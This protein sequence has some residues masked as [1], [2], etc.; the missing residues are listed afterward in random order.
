MLSASEVQANRYL[1]D[2]VYCDESGVAGVF[3]GTD[4]PLDGVTLDIVCT[5]ADAEVCLEFTT[6]TGTLHESV[7][8]GKFN[9]ECA[10]VKTFDPTVDLSG[11]YLV[12]VAGVEGF[13]GCL[14]PVA[15]P[16][17]YL[18]TV[19]VDP[20]TLPEDC[21]G[22][23]TPVVGGPP[24]NGNGDG[25]FCDP[26]DGPFPEGQILGDGSIDQAT[27]EAS[28]SPGPGD[29]VHTVLVNDPIEA[30]CSLFA[31]FGYEPGEPFC[32]DGSVNA[33]GETCDPP[34]SPAGGNGNLCR[35][36]CT[37]CGDSIVDPGEDCDDGNG[38]PGDGCE[39]D[40]T[41]SP[42][43]GN[44]VLD[45]GETCDPPGFPAGGNGKLCR[46]S[47]TVC[48]DGI[49]NNGEAC[50]DGN[51]ING[52][53]C[54]NDCTGGFL[55]KELLEG[56]EQIGIYL[57]T[58]TVF[59]F[60]ITYFGPAALVLDTVPAEFEI[61]EVV[62]SDGTAIFFQSG[63]SGKSATK[64]EWEVPAGLNTLTVT[65]QTRPSPGKGHKEPVFKPTSCGPLPL[66][67][68]ATATTVGT[69]NALVVEA[70]EGAKPCVEEKVDK[71]ILRVDSAGTGN[72]GQVRIRGMLDD[73]KTGGDLA[74]SLLNGL[75]TLIVTDGAE[76]NAAIELTNCAFRRKGMIRCGSPRAIIKPSRKQAL[77]Y[78]LQVVARGLG[79]S[80]TGTAQPQGPITLK[81]EDNE[82]VEWEIEIP[83][84]A[85]KSRGTTMLVCSGK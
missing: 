78:K 28:A 19:T 15:H 1:G 74:T 42:S 34:G 13:G 45:P 25:D 75:V 63:Q 53:G 37:V 55:E 3:D 7:D 68:G 31:D 26:E 36:D 17:P 35:S 62:A 33:P 16:S 14:L 8:A 82:D 79:D 10:A 27:C 41:V 47:C 46:S 48:G 84:A 73:R 76:F 29:G 21:D 5:D 20:N 65:I 69:S 2:L 18:C 52:D 40:C 72:N 61:V 83:S 71:A 4:F 58:A 49:I 38:T 77:V 51:G 67:D 56:P 23:L 59:V 44:G 12:E 85:C 66:N 80:D 57:P 11:R 43:C 24:F 70:V 39:N 6:V 32:G 81:L 22:L 60:E 50:D 64:I 54:D 9:N 30:I